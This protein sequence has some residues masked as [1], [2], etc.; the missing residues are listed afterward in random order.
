[1]SDFEK[2]HPNHWATLSAKKGAQHQNIS[3]KWR[4]FAQSGRTVCELA[5]ETLRRSSSE[6]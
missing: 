6:E 1:L 3:P 4:N 2:L 5:A